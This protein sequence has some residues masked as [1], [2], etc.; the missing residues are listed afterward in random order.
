MLSG[1]RW[2]GREGWR[3]TTRCWGWCWGCCCK[4]GGRWMRIVG[5]W[6]CWGWTATGICEDWGKYSGLDLKVSEVITT[7]VGTDDNTLGLV[8]KVGKVVKV[9]VVGA[10][11][12][13]VD[14]LGDV[15]VDVVN[16]T[17]TEFW[18]IGECVLRIGCWTMV[19]KPSM[20]FLT[21]LETGIK[22]VGGFGTENVEEMTGR[23][24]AASSSVL[25][26]AMRS[27]NGSC[28]TFGKFGGKGN[29]GMAMLVPGVGL[30][31]RE[32]LRG[33]DF[34][35]PPR[36]VRPRLPR[37]ISSIC[38]KEKKKWCNI[39]YKIWYDIQTI[40]LVCLMLLL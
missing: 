22:V 21:I 16:G 27:S 40:T 34:L 28:L 39:S 3:S 7:L 11:N 1:L 30:T 6:G 17:T 10:T 32:V 5:C 35:L 4:P 31:I 37:P 29:N 12:W 20:G 25:T 24:W 19:T 8:V 13:V 38:K 9:V 33:G 23:G 2:C 26:T 36:I 14:K 15:R 18:R